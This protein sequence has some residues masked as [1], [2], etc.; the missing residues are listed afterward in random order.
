M[1]VLHNDVLL[2]YEAHRIPVRPMLPDNGREF[3]GTEGHPYKLYLE[4]NE[5]EHRRTTVSKPQ[6]NGFVE[7][8][9]HTVLDEFLRTAFAP[10]STSMLNNSRATWTNG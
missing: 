5:I 2:F 8:F 6:I 9:N 7:R 3:C 1:S 4:L 10:P